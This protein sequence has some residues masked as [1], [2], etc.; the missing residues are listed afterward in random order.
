MKQRKS[1]HKT[2]K[3]RRIQVIC[4]FIIATILFFSK[5]DN[6]TA[7]ITDMLHR[8]DIKKKSLLN[9][10]Y[11]NVSDSWEIK[12][13][14]RLERIYA[15]CGD[16]CSV[17]NVEK[18]KE[19]S[20]QY[21]G[22]PFRTL[23]TDSV[24]CNAILQSEDIDAVDLTF[25]NLP[26][27]QIKRFYTMD[28]AIPL[29]EGFMWKE[30]QLEN[31]NSVMIW[32][33]EDI[34]SQIRNV[35]KMKGSYGQKRIV[36]E[37]RSHI[38]KI[39]MAGKSA[40]VIG[41]QTPWVE[42]LCLVA[43]ASSVTTLEYAPILSLHPRIKVYTPRRFRS[44]YEAGKIGQFDVVVSFSSVEHSGLGRYG[45]ALNPWGDIL[46]VGRAYCITKKDGHMILGL[47]TGKDRV[48]WNANR[49]Y[50]VHRWPLVTVNWIQINENR[51]NALAESGNTVFTFKKLQSEER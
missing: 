12:L 46:A 34:E 4:I 33:K 37:L 25:P 16:L 23:V 30:E 10:S 38:E 50:G 20:K 32:S 35:D 1:T 40:L 27:H 15:S 22:N 47:P 49:V 42:I 9:I 11:H 31:K 48:R 28:G 51:T 13:F 41:S 29:N 43:G 14:E 8:H 44:N 24:N 18:L 5:L 7:N 26:P 19:K 3:R 39:G 36:D 6:I 45:D 21:Q 2:I 17:N